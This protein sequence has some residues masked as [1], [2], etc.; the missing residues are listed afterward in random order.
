M[1]GSFGS[2]ITL[3]CFNISTKN[4]SLTFSRQWYQNGDAASFL[5]EGGHGHSMD[6]EERLRLVR[7][8]LSS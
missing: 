4:S 3:V 5:K 7:P 6:F 2:L 8:D 1:F